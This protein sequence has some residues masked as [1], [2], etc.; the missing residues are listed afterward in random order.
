MLRA[1]LTSWWPPAACYGT[2]LYIARA[3]EP[4]KAR[5]EA[6]AVLD[7]VVVGLRNATAT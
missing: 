6:D 5:V 2:A 7:A 4:T 3:A 1:V